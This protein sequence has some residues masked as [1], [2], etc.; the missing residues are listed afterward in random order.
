MNCKGFWL[1]VFCFFIFKSNAQE[2]FQE[3]IT[4]RILLIYDCSNSM[5]GKWQSDTK[6]SIS[7]KLLSDI[8]D[9]LKNTPNLELALRVYGHQSSMPPMDCNDTKLEVPF[10]KNNIKQIIHKIKTLV[11]KGATPIANSLMMAADD[12]PACSNCR[13]IIVLITDGI[14]ECGGDACAASAYLQEKGIVLKPF[15]IGI[16]KNF[17]ESFNCVG[18]Y[19][20]ASEE[21]E[22]T[23]AFNVVISQAL[24][25]TTA[26]VNLFDVNGNPT[27]TNVNMTFYDHLSGKMMYNYVHAMNH[28][29]ISDTITLDPLVVYDLEIQTYPIVKRDS[30]VLIA[31]Q[32]NIIS[33]DAPQGALKL[34][35]PG[36]RAAV[37]KS[38][39]AIIRQS[40][41]MHT[42]NV[43]YVNTQEKYIVGKYDLEILCM[44]RI[45]LR[46]VQ[47]SQSTTT[48]VELPMIGI[49]VLNKNIE[50]YGSLYAQQGNRLELIYNMGDAKMET[51]HLQPGKY[52]A[53]IRSKYVHRADATIEKTFVIEPNATTTVTF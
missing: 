11:P 6:M 38:I 19:F 16:G 43:Q 1:F 18:N 52:K 31:G 4:T 26:Q 9:S 17:Q 41:N 53:I 29:G 40:G 12:F 27:E 3:P 37:A 42:V 35:M 13:N 25:S 24:N 36:S 2:Q 22:F 14:E 28:R 50:G 10:G 7:K 51:L 39:P 23:K 15:V 20:D 32:H 33:L 34:V 44:P 8:L 30:I 5:N 46:D 45:Y 49:L 47:V 21:T 48:T